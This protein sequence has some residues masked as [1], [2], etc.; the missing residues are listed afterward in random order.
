MSAD[1]EQLLQCLY[2]ESV[3][4]LILLIR[5]LENDVD[6][7]ICRDVGEQ[8]FNVKA[9]HELVVVWLYFRYSVHEVERVSEDEVV[10]SCERFEDFIEILC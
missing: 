6:S 5:S 10:V 9:Y 7:F 8:R 3:K 4:C 1:D 2:F